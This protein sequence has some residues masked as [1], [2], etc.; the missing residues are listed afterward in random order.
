MTMAASHIRDLK[1]Y[2]TVMNRPKILIFIFNEK[3]ARSLLETDLFSST[4]KHFDLKLVSTARNL[5]LDQYRGLGSGTVSYFHFPYWLQRSGTLIATANLWSKRDR[6][7]AHYL[8]AVSNF[9]NSK[10]RRS[11]RGMVL[12]KM[13]GWGNFKRFI[14]RVLGSSKFFLILSR[15]RNHFV[16][17]KLLRLFKSMDINPL[18][19]QSAIVPF[20]GLLS[21]EFDDIIFTLN[22]MGITSIALQE[23][24][25]NLSSKTFVRSSPTYF[26]VWGNQSAGHLRKIH[27]NR[28]SKIV[29]IGSARFSP[30]FFPDEQYR[31]NV[32]NQLGLLKTKYVLITGTGDGIDDK[33]LIVSTLFA[34][35][36]PARREI[37]VVYRPHP[38]T[39][40]PISK[41]ELE[42][43]IH[44]GLI[45]DNRI[46]ANGVYHHCDLVANALL[47]INQFSTVLL[48]ALAAN[49]KVLLP[50]YIERDINYDWS[51]AL[52]EWD[53]LSGI[54]L[55]PN[56]FLAKQKIDFA[57]ALDVAL[58]TPSV[59]SAKSVNWFCANVTSHSILC[60][61]LLHSSN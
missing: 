1:L 3:Q 59:D 19:S 16:Y 23:N 49:V 15:L 45:V 61:L 20:S 7:G 53:H 60:N 54:L 46:G 24:W 44:K 12:Y 40:N 43:L 41:A 14:V 21:P 22:K 8:R 33:E 9:G 5:S 38:F 37:V 6:S 30:Y 10:A 35:E 2:I 56:T 39:R 31:S 27:G 25:D 51:D 47:V 32:R 11:L 36:T 29:V 28:S 18:S 34:I 50:T 48:E 17:R 52:L 55:L 13:D 42:R 58:E 26:C 4:Q 57:K